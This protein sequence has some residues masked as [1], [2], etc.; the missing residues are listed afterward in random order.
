MALSGI[1]PF[2]VTVNTPFFNVELTFFADAV[3]GIENPTHIHRPKTAPIIPT[4]FFNN[5]LLL[6]K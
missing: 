5:F 6:L 3:S 1:F 2:P 4:E